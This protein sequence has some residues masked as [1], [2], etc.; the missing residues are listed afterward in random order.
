MKIAWQDGTSEAAA[1]DVDTGLIL[2]EI[3]EEG[4]RRH[5]ALVRGDALGVYISR[6]AARKAIE[7]K[8]NEN[9]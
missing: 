6:E 9:G 3:F 4:N 2:G 7:R 1:Y 5:R 8:L